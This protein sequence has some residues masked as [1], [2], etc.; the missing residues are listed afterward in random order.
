M[1][2]SGSG[3]EPKRLALNVEARTAFSAEAS[4]KL[5]P[6]LLTTRAPTG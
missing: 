1:M 4:S 3:I 5:D 2:V 6:L